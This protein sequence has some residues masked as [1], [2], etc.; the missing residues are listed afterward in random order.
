MLAGLGLSWGQNN[1]GELGDP[2][3]TE[4]YVPG[5][6]SMPTGVTFATITT[7]AYHTAALTTAGD[8]YAWGFNI[9][10]QLGDGT[11]TDAAT[12]VQSTLPMGTTVTQLVAGVAHNLALTSTGEVYAWGYNAYGQLGDGTTTDRDTPVP[13]DLPVGVTISS[14]GAGWNHSVA[15]TSTGELLA[16]GDNENGQLGDGTTTNSDTPVQ[17]LLPTGVTVTT[18]AGGLNHSL[19]VTFTGEVLAWGDNGNGQLG[20]GTLTARDTPVA[21][22]PAGVTVT[23]VRGG[24]NLSFALTSTGGALVWGLNSAGQLGDG[25]AIDRYVPGAV[26]L[27]PGITLTGIAGHMLTCLAVT[28]TGTLL[29]WGSG[30]AGPCGDGTAADRSAPVATF[31]PAETTIAGAD[32]FWTF[33]A[34]VT[35]PPPP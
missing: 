24:Q 9:F 25:T 6:V 14:V 17:V 1:F 27:P 23:D 31:L 28:S 3:A 13:V 10:G 2:M 26:N 8:V 18:A 11:T 16:W 7:G 33:A 20:D 35:G 15:V 22:W 29:A 12:P 5:E 21:T 34:A 19:A 32:A 30:G 4:R